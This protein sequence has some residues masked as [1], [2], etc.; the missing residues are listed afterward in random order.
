MNLSA[1]FTQI[2]PVLT[3]VVLVCLGI[4]LRRL[5]VLGESDTRTIRSVVFDLSLP[6]L[7]FSNLYTST[8]PVN[9]LWLIPGIILLQLAGYA[10]FRAVPRRAKETVFSSLL[11]NTGFMGFPVTQSI[12]GAQALPFSIIIDQ[13]H[14]FMIVST[15]LHRNMRHL[16]NPPLAALLLALALKR[17][18][19]PAFLLD[20]CKLVGDTASPLAMIFIGL[21]F[22]PGFSWISVLVAGIKL[23]AVPAT[24]LLITHLLPIHG[25]LRSAFVL[26]CAMPTMAVSVIY[27]A[28]IGL[29][30]QKLAR[31]V[32]VCTLLFPFTLLFWR[33]FL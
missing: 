27:G 26:E 21:N 14:S 3:L 13:T 2:E 8:I 32:V 5:H 10:V 1:I 25:L 33:L 20:S 11:G 9:A 19:L 16:I 4:A 22:E 29:D 7:I 6:A 23:L 15:W 31:N 24:A 30:I 18:P 17:V 12:L 28:E